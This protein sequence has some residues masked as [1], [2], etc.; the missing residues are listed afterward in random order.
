MTIDD[1]LILKLEDLSK[2]N[3]T[4]TERSLI[5]KD[6]EKIF[7][8]FEKLNEVDTKN[9]DPFIHFNEATDLSQ[10]AIGKQVSNEDALKNAPSK[11]KP[12]FTVPKIID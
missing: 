6:L 12:F 9:V 11:Q 4:D 5:K 1:K 7:T 8:M 3:L 2:L 10:D